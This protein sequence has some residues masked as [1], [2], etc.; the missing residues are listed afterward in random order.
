MTKKLFYTEEELPQRQNLW[1]EMRKT[2]IGGS[3]I[4]SILGISK[5]IDTPIRLWKRKTGRLAPKVVNEAMIRGAEMEEEA[6]SVIQKYLT[7]NEGIKNPKMDGY[8]AKHPDYDFLGVSYDGVDIENKFIT[9]LKCPNFSSVF[10]SVLLDGIQDYYYP[11]V[12]SQLFI[13]NA[14]WDIDKAYYCSYYPNG[15]YVLDTRTY[16]ED[17]V[18]LAVLDVDY[19]AEFCDQMLAVAK[20]FWNNVQ[21]DIWDKDEYAGVLKKFHEY[22]NARS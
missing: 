21:E 17:F 12:Q 9:E 22:Y 7:K 6:K 1:L 19:D 10:K 15:T 20:V 5:K 16:I 3:D 11:Q 13:S 8:F 18:D 14:I 2:C 4:A